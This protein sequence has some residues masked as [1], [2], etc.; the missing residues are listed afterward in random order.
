MRKHQCFGISFL[1]QSIYV[2]FHFSWKHSC[3]VA[4]VLLGLVGQCFSYCYAQA[5]LAETQLIGPSSDGMATLLVGKPIIRP[6]PVQKAPL[7]AIVDFQTSQDC[8]A[9]LTINDGNRSWQQVLPGFAREHRAAVLGMSPDCSH[10]IVV[11]VRDKGGD[12]TQNSLPMRHDTPPLP[13]DFPPIQTLSAVSSQMEPGIT[14]FAVNNWT[15][16]VS[17]VDYGYLIALDRSGQVVWYCR[18]GDRTSDFRVL[19][20]GNLLYQHGSYRYLYEIDLLG[21]DLRCWY[22]ARTTAAPNAEAI[23]VDVDTMHHEVVELPNGN[24]MTLSTEL[25]RFS[26]Y[27]TSET[28]RTAPWKPAWVVCDEVVEFSPDTGQIIRRLSLTEFLDS[29]RFGYLALGD[30]WRDKYNEFLD[31]PARDWSHAN[32]L[33]YLPKD[34]CILVSFRHLDCIL[35]IGWSDRKLRWILGDPTNWSERHQQYLLKPEGR[36]EWF[37][38]QHAPHITAAGT[39]LMF[40]NGN[41][42]AVPYDPP[43][44]AQ[45][46]SSRVVAYQIDEASKTVRQVYSFGARQGED[47]Y[48]PFFGEAELLPETGNLL[49]T[50]GGR[51]ETEEG[52]PKDEVPGHRQWARILEITGTQRPQ[53]VFETVCQSPLGSRFGWSIYRANRYPGL[54]NP[55]GTELEKGELRPRVFE[56]PG[57]QKVNPLTVYQPEVVPAQADQMSN[58]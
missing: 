52:L 23:A 46:N 5:V 35:K 42:R 36:L 32:A 9:V 12:R 19:R 56:R 28:D 34:D 45:H 54:N 47:F 44:A 57:I 49:I 7:V 2:L 26:R 16:D 6:N 24:L 33:Q 11:T 20:N 25:R 29:Q 43:I 58:P 1:M 14:M 18:T 31:A 27:P 10:Q 50:D 21:R 48:A 4:I 22:A 15:D 51:I 41:Y 8:S 39:L 37:Y 55:F 40:D 3:L 13:S 17:L 53:K 38:H 30:F